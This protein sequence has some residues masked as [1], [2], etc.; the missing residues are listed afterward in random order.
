MNIT[1]QQEVE[2]YEAYRRLCIEIYDGVV[3]CVVSGDTI[4]KSWILKKMRWFF[5]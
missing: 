3:D 5:R 2:K 1:K 4:A